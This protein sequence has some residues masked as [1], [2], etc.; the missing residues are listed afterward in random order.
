AVLSSAG[1]S[2]AIQ[3]WGI[4]LITTGTVLAVSV[5]VIVAIKKFKRQPP[6]SKTETTELLP[7]DKL[8]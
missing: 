5:A 3:G 1:S 4:G 6:G 8:K 2:S 7:L